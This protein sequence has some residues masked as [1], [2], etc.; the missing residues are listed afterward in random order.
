MLDRIVL[1][2]KRLAIELE[3][4]AKEKEEVEEQ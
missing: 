1:G 4:E 3:Q 2:A